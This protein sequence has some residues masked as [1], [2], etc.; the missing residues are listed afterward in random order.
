MLSTTVTERFAESADRVFAALDRC[1]AGAHSVLE[2]DPEAR[3][4]VF[5]TQASLFSWGHVVT[6]RVQPVGRSAEVSL[7]VTGAPAAPTA[8]LDGKKNR[9]MGRKVLAA[10]RAEV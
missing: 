5:R 4:L 2:R 10:L 6:A 9:A 1:A 3:I 8:L 7:T